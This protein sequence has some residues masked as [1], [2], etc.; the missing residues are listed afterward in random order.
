MI[1]NIG[2]GTINICYVKQMDYLD[3][4]ISTKNQ[5]MPYFLKWLIY[6]YK[7]IAKI[8]TVKQVEDKKIVI[9]PINSTGKGIEKWIKYLCSVLYDSNLD[10][11]VLSNSLKKVQGIKEQL[12]SENIRVLE[13]TLLRENLTV[14]LVEYIANE[15]NEEVK[16]LEITVLV[17]QNKKIYIQSILALAEVTKNI[18]IVTNNVDDFKNLEQKMQELYGI[19]IRVTNNKRKSLA[20]SSIIIN[21]DFPEELVNKFVINPDAIIVNISNQ[22]KIKAKQ[23]SGINMHDMKLLIKKNYNREFEKNSVYNDF[24][25]KEIYESSIVNMEFDEVQRKLVKDNVYINSLIGVNGP[26]NK[27]EFEEKCEKYVKSLDK[28]SRLN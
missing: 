20:K 19:L 12:N 18:K 13:G 24:D 9:I 27:K 28:L 1:K 7:K 26:I 14:K 2:G 8:F 22:V 11:V 5:K 23:F 4:I 3:E 25:A 16:N 6:N 15:M 10:T 21:L 17:N